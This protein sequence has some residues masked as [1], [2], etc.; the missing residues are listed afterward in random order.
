MK[1]TSIILLTMVILIIAC[2][3]EDI[4][5][6]KPSSKTNLIDCSRCGGSWDITDSIP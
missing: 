1:K 2:K 4:N 3:K 6:L 5:P